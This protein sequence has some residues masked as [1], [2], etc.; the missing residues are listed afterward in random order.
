MSGVVSVGGRHTVLTTDSWGPALMLLSSVLAH[1]LWLPYRN[2]QRIFHLGFSPGGCKSCI[3]E[4][5][6]KTKK[7]KKRKKIT[8]LDIDFEM[9]SLDNDHT[10][11]Y[12]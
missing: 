5:E 4:G 2:D 7:E 12:I 1:N 11:M 6:Y 9:T 10:V 3:G 8:S